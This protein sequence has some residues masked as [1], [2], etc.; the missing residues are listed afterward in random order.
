MGSHRSGLIRLVPFL[1]V[2]LGL[3][4]V[5]VWLRAP[6]FAFNHWNVDEAIHAAAARILLEGGVL[7]RDAIDQRTPLTY[8]LEAAVF[9]LCGVNNLT[10]VRFA[11]ALLIAATGTCLFAAARNLGRP[12]AGLG[13]GL[14]FV[15]L[16][17]ATF[18]VGD[19]NAAH[20]EWCVAFFSSAAIATFTIRSISEAKRSF[21]TGV[22]LGLAFLSK[23]PAL[24]DLLAPGTVILYATHRHGVK[25][26]QAI[27]QLTAL[28]AGWL[29]PVVLFAGYFVFKGAWS[30]TVFYTW[31]YNL[32][33]YG[34]ETDW[35][36]RIVAAFRGMGLIV[37]TAPIISAVCFA[38]V[39]IILIKLAQRQPTAHE[40]NWHT[41]WLYL[42]MW[43]G[44]SWAGAAS[45]GR[46]FQ[47]YFITALPVFSLGSALSLSGMI[48]YLPAGKWKAAG[49]CIM[50]AAAW[51]PLSRALDNRG[52]KLPTDPSVQVS[53]YIKENS[54]IDDTVFVWGYHPDIYVFADRK[55]ASRFLYASF[56]T[57]LIPWTN[58]DPT[59][60]TSYAI[61]P[62]AMGKLLQDLER[63]APKFI[64][65]CS[66]GPNRYWGKYPIDDF[67]RLADY[68]KAHYRLEAT[69]EFIPQGFRLYRRLAP[70][71][72]AS[73][74]LPQPLSKDEIADFTLPVV[75]NPIQAANGTAPWGT[76]VRVH[77]GRKEYFLHAPSRITFPLSNLQGGALLRGGCGIRPAAYAE[78][79]PGP[80]DGAEFIIRWRPLAG[81]D[82][83]LWQRFLAPKTTES[84][85]GIQSFSIVIPPSDANGG[86]LELEIRPGPAENFA[87]DWTF[88]SDLMLENYQ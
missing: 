28:S 30:D 44:S 33:Y 55:P 82:T 74:D 2:L 73:T 46:D 61:V 35:I 36:D 16:G 1:A 60:E 69:G 62:E 25:I 65:D 43:A 31:T 56:L 78:N 66:A 53:R 79:N 49:A 63:S 17:T 86:I 81:E 45:S 72:T 50:I 47:H 19:A 24:L 15:V 54:Q 75:G 67:P 32:T 48:R 18:A 52:R 10:A 80:T 64:V 70:G 71:E 51:Q 23:Q 37:T 34:P 12:M 14:L 13:A 59:R 76:E 87:S 5:A 84:D 9:A 29:L 6:T 42:L 68:L 7:Y 8:Y 41:I 21:A 4:L 83:V 58:V 40:R 22:L 85:R 26:K 77:D 38:A 11:T 20:T 57:G 39:V 27:A 88:W 3:M